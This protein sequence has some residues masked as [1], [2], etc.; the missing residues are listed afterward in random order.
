MDWP[1]NAPFAAAITF[2][3]DADSLIHAATPDGWQQPYAIS[4]GQ[5][6]PTVGVPRILETY[7]RL[8]LRQTFFI[9]GWCVKT[10]PRAV[11]AILQGGHEIGCHGWIHENPQART[12]AEQAEDLDRALDA[13]AAFAGYRPRGYRAPVYLL[14]NDTPRLI[15]DRGFAYDSSMMADDDPY[16]LDLG[17]GRSL[18]EIPTHWGI[19]DWPPFAHYAEIGYMMPVR[20]PTEGLAPF[21]EEFE[22]ARQDAGLWHAVWHPFLTGRR[23]RWQVVERWL[24]TALTSGA[25]F[26]TLGQIADHAETLRKAGR[27][28]TLPFPAYTERQT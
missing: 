18:I 13:I 16:A 2:D 14:T 1:M 4:M 3:M 11:E 23:A 9:P 5:Y 28:R 15:A 25:W 17:Q 20:G 26:A 10:Y 7:R 22:A 12:V 6:G 8:G 24:E 19:D 27:L 21:F